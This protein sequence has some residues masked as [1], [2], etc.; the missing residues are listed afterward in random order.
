M[1]TALEEIYYFEVARGGFAYQ[2]AYG[3]G[4]DI[5]REVRTG[6]AVLLPR[7]YHGPSM[8]APGYDLYYLNVMAGPGERAWR[9]RDDPAHAWIR[10]TWAD[11]EID[12]QTSDDG[13]PM[14]LDGGAGARPVP[15]EPAHGA[16]RVRAAADRRAASGSS[17]TA[18]WPASGRR[19]SSSPRRCP[20][21]TRATSRG[22]CTRRRATR[23]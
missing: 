16:R 12:P 15:G 22:W 14:R 6:D 13:G 17:G 4:I 23:G 7:G 2:R 3:G 19:C 10:N 11:Q 20:T 8:A 21:T 1:E 18:T 5:C 9:F